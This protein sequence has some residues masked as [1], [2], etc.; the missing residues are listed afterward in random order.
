M[1]AAQRIRHAVAQVS[2]LR[3]EARAQPGLQLAM[4]AIKRLQAR[5]F[6][7]SY[8]DLLADPKYA[9]AAR[10]FLDEL[11]SDKDY[12]ERD[13]QFSRIAGALEKLFPQHVV[14]TAVELANLHMLTEQLDHD[15]AGRWLLDEPAS[16]GEAVRYARAWRAVGR[17][18]DR[19]AQLEVVMDIGRELERLTRKPGLRLALRMMRG[20][21]SA[22][23]MG[24]LQ[25]FLEAGFDTF[26][27]LA[28]Q[29]QGV[30]VF[31]E[32][33]RSRELALINMLFDSDLVACETRLAQTLGQAR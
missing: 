25:T 4:S 26:A 24:S 19:L 6:A 20:P 7:G 12:A 11:Y 18:E 3:D 16:G 22:A 30:E 14:T 13:A 21:A 32:T 29:R 17:R 23:G 2:G 33:I 10:F 9:S 31:L 1:E 27:Q 5:R 15:M 28:R 8:A